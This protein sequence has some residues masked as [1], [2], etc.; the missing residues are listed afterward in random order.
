MMGLIYAMRKFT[1][2]IDF[3]KI[4]K[5]NCIALLKEFYFELQK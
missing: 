3:I 5:K 2:Q 4:E 1:F